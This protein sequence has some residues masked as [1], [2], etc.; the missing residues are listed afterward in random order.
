MQLQP[1][2]L[3]LW[4]KDGGDA[5]ALF[6]GGWSRYQLQ[7]PEVKDQVAS[8][9]EGLKTVLRAYRLHPSKLNKKLDVLLPLLADDSRT[10]WVQK[11]LKS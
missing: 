6:M 7:H 4:G 9:T 11:Q 10:D 3:K 5:L 1:Y 8:N 2:L